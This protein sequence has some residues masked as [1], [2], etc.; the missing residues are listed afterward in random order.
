VLA[1]MNTDQ[2]QAKVNQAEAYL[3]WA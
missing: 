2:L 1:R 3:N